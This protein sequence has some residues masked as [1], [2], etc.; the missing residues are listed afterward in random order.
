METGIVMNGQLEA[1]TLKTGD[2]IRLSKGNLHFE[3]TVQQLEIFRKE[4]GTALVGP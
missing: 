4:S 1:G 3:D 2:K